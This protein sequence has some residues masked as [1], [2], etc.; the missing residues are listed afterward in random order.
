MH[1]RQ[2]TLLAGLAFTFAACAGR[3]PGNQTESGV[4]DAEAGESTLGE[5]VTETNPTGVDTMQTGGDTSAVSDSAAAN[6]T[7]AGVVDTETGQATT[8]EDIS[9]IDATDE[10]EGGTQ[11]G[12]AGQDTT[13][14]GAAG[15]DTTTQTTQKPP[16]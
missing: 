1:M 5:D 2:I 3:Q 13:Q 9:E 6:Q 7:E 4:T 14:A 12:A 8:G 15:Q 10:S 16:K 11:G